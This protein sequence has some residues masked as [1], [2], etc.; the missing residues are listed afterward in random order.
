MFNLPYLMW[1]SELTP[2]IFSDERIQVEL[3]EYRSNKLIRTVEQ[4]KD[5]PAFLDSRIG[6]QFINEA[7]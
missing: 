7:L 3:K 4:V 1:L 2:T 5:S 6:L